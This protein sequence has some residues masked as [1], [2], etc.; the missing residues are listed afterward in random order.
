MNVYSRPHAFLSIVTQLLAIAWIWS[1]WFGMASAA[2][3]QNGRS[4]EADLIREELRQLRKD[5][6]QRLQDLEE[7]LRRP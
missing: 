5:Y 2:R 1:S 7:R 6:E 4:S 3:A